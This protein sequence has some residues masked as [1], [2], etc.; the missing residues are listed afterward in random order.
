MVLW[1]TTLSTGF[2]LLLGS[3]CMGVRVGG[4]VYRAV[5]RGVC[6]VWILV[7]LSLVPG[8]RL[9]VNLM[10]VSVIS[11]LGIP[12]GVLLQVIALMP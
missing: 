10:N 12:G 8:M 6:A 7:A 11:A 2:F 1:V 3:F 4:R 5:S 9:G